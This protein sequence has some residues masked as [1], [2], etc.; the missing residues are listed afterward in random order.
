VG[1]I[2]PSPHVTDSRTRTL[3][4]ADLLYQFFG[5]SIIFH[6]KLWWR[7]LF[8]NFQ[9]IL[10][11]LFWIAF[12]IVDRWLRQ[13]YIL[14]LTYYICCLYNQCN[15][16]TIITSLILETNVIGVFFN[17]TFSLLLL[18]VFHSRRW[19]FDTCSHCFHLHL[20]PSFADSLCL[21]CYV[22]HLRH[23]WFVSLVFT[24]T[25]QVIKG[26]IVVTL[27]DAWVYLHCETWVPLGFTSTPC[28]FSWQ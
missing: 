25:S 20:V 13:K 5:F 3:V 18:F 27:L 21:L 7:L 12:P 9:I 24:L 22:L 2:I 15:R 10:I 4:F 17:L 16:Y 26:G 14:V 28:R 23:V 8:P 6:D 11:Y 1:V 19:V